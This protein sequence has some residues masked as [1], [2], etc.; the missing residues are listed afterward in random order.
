MTDNA[1][2]LKIEH[3]LK[4][5][6]N[7][8]RPELILLFYYYWHTLKHKPALTHSHTFVQWW[9]RLPCKVPS[10]HHVAGVKKR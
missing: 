2:F 5:K 7:G 6:K 9:Q 1:V 3:K 4:I 8:K 10:A